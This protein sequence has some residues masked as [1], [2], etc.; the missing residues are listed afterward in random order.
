MRRQSAHKR[1]SDRALSEGRV[2]RYGKCDGTYVHVTYLVPKTQVDATLAVQLA[3]ISK[4]E[5]QYISAEVA[6]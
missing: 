3:R 4:G 2:I 1:V 6:S 5:S